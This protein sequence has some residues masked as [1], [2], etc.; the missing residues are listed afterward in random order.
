MDVNS[1]IPLKN[2][3]SYE[4]K[5]GRWDEAELHDAF[6]K[7]NVVEIDFA[8]IN[9]PP[10]TFSL[11][12][13]GSIDFLDT[14][15]LNRGTWRLKVTKVG[16]L[17]R[18]DDL[19]EGGKK[20]LNRKWKTWSVIL[21]GS[22]LLFCRDPTVASTLLLPS[23]AFDC[24]LESLV[25]RPDEFLSLK[26]AIA[27]YDRSYVK[28]TFFNCS[29]GVTGL[30]GWQYDHT[31]RFIMSDGRHLLLQAANE[32]DL[33][34]WISR[35]NYASTFKTA[36]VRMRAS[37]LSEEEVFRTGVA[38]ATSHLHDTH[39]K[40]SDQMSHSSLSIAP[41]E[42][43]DM[44]TSQPKLAPALTPKMTFEAGSSSFALES[45][46]SPESGVEEFKLT[47]DQVKADLAVESLSL[48]STRNRSPCL[49]E[50]SHKSPQASSDTSVNKY[51]R[52]PP[53]SQAILSKIR[54]I[55]SRMAS[56]QS[57]L[58]S[59]ER[60]ARN[61]A[62][63]TPFRKS[64]RSRLLSAIQNL[65]RPIMQMRLES[66]KLRCH[67]TVLQSDLMSECQSRIQSKQIALR[68]A[69]DALPPCRPKTAP[70]ISLSK[71]GDNKCK[72]SSDNAMVLTAGTRAFLTDSDSSQSSG[73]FV[74]ARENELD[75]M[76]SHGENP[77]ISP[78]LAL[79]NSD[80]V[81]SSLSLLVQAEQ[82]ELDKKSLSKSKEHHDHSKK[83]DTPDSVSHDDDDDEQA[84]EWNKTRVAQRVSLIHVPSDIRITTRLKQMLE[85]SFDEV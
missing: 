77:T 50:S 48:E 84:E 45:P 28:V 33:Q 6:I 54:E 11:Y 73:S 2:P 75:W 39:R 59:D 7:G 70:T 67:R 13:G 56:L 80:A 76:S 27:L 61:I 26:D 53:R 71:N 34:Q 69:R 10:A 49:G 38:A 68:V 64:T 46:V 82:L 85:G 4:G 55:D 78:K 79:R 30:I 24:R 62:V 17:N 3:Y 65:A 60:Y 1:L 72:F 52:F 19:I 37:A 25:L 23:G 51:S 36:G 47:F 63:L 29:I 41:N 58:E 74:S 12:A 16:V 31:F 35:I 83:N 20:A 32:E 8:T 43:M 44:L 18:K 15:H 40:S 5:N 21:T 81:N 9:R 66:E 14:N 57:Q 42:L 22:Q